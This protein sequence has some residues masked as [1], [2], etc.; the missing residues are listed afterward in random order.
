MKQIPRVGKAHEYGESRI[1]KF[2][3]G[4]QRCNKPQRA[5]G[6]KH[7]RSFCMAFESKT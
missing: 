3:V 2:A 6:E 4:E 1:F 7:M 5:I